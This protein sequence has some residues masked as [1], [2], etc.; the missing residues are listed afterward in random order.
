MYSETTVVGRISWM[1]ELKTLDEDRSVLNF[2][3]AVDRSYTNNS[4]E[5]VDQAEFFTIA[6][7]NGQ[8][9]STSQYK[10]VGD[11]VLVVGQMQ[12]DRIEDTNG[13]LAGYWPKLKARNVR[14]LP[15]GNRNGDYNEEIPDPQAATV[16]PVQTEPMDDIPF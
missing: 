4:G 6:V 9:R 1:G 11:P 5:K 12:F 16:Q 15:G 3:V 13:K 8:A 7:W 2:Q 10:Q 14:F